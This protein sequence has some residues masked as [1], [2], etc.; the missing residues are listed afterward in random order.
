MNNLQLIY[1]MKQDQY[2]SK[3]NC[4]VCSLDEISSL[5]LP[6]ENYMI[7]YNTKNFPHSGH[8]CLMHR[9]EQRVPVTFDSF[10]DT[11]QHIVAS[12]LI[13]TSPNQ[14]YI[15]NSLQVQDYS[16]TTCGFYVLYLA[17]HLARGLNLT[18]ILSIFKGKPLLYIESYVVSFVKTHFSLH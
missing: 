6:I 17:Y 10:G 12:F 8:W 7:I 11:P 9:K 1:A 13:E 3:F 2:I 15:K 14:K 18:E 16:M 4:K 5:S